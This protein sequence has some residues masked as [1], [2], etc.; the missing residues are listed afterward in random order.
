VRT[1]RSH[2]P[3][4]RRPSSRFKNLA[5]YNHRVNSV[6]IYSAGVRFS[7]TPYTRKVEWPDGWSSAG[8]K[9]T[10]RKLREYNVPMARGWESKSVEAQQEE[11]SEKSSRSGNPKMSAKEAAAFREK[12]AL[13]LARQRVTQQLEAS[14]SPRHRK[15]LQDA[16]AALDEKLE[17]L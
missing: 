3:L 6:N 4:K 16:L 15:V 12:E 2:L 14:S 9:Q 10:R 8:R 11:A 7:Q 5:H 17:R 1:L 13:R